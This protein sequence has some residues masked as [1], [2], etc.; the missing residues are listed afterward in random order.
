MNLS[1]VPAV[2]AFLAFALALSANHAANKVI[3]RQSELTHLIVSL[4]ETQK[5][6]GEIKP[7]RQRPS[8]G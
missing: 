6:L 2:V 8:K 1:T 3:S 7:L 5:V 4:A